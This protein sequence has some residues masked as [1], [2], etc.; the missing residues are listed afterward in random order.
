M[1]LT[2]DKRLEYEYMIQE[3]R[4]HCR[5][6]TD[7]SVFQDELARIWYREWIY[8]GHESEVPEAGDYVLKWLGL[9]PVIMSRD[10]DGGVNLLLNHCTH[11][12]AAICQDEQGNSHGFRCW[13]HGWRFNNKGE[14]I[15]V[16]HPKGF[17]DDFRREDFGL[18]RVPRTS[19]YRGFLF[20][21]MSPD[22]ISLDEHL[23]PAKREVF[24]RLCDLSPQGEVEIQAGWLKHRVDANWKMMMEN[25]CDFYHPSFTHKAALS[26]RP[27]LGQVVR[28]LGNGHADI[29]SLNSGAVAPSDEGNNLG[30]SGRRHFDALARVYGEDRAHAMLL[31]GTPHAIIF[32]NLFVANQ[33]LFVV[34]P[35]AAGALVSYQ[36]PVY[37]KGVPDE[38]NER[39]LRRFEGASGPA[40]LLEQDDGEIWERNQRGLQALMPEW[41]VLKRGFGAETVTPEGIRVARDVMDETSMRGFWR[42]YKRLILATKLNEDQGEDRDREIGS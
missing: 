40:G 19:S 35:V 23:G 11:R 41:Q 1:V 12:G 10:E 26:E 13:Y 25:V 7:E 5:L 36:T 18:A 28:D 15:G 29:H 37:F 39:Q 34:R 24:D 21:N 2:S 17:P 32:P 30:E 33:N 42:H 9:Q 20:G 16:A 14:C 31:D 8:I 38:V 3:D 22:G 27:Y 6:Y 4:V